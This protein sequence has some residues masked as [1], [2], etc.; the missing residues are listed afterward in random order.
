MRDFLNRLKRQDIHI[1]VQGNNLAIDAP[2]ADVMD[3]F[4][5]EIKSRKDDIIRYLTASNEK[6][7]EKYSRQVRAIWHDC[8][9]MLQRCF[10]KHDGMTETEAGKAAYE[11]LKYTCDWIVRDAMESGL[12]EVQW[13]IENEVKNA[14]K[15]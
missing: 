6:I 5:A 14:V 4:R 12:T 8:M 7:P 3:R 11:F 1:K 10:M 15:D 2:S 13:L 9:G